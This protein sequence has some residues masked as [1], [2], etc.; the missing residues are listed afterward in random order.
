MRTAELLTPSHNYAVVKLPERSH[1]GVVFQG[2]SL[3]VLLTDISN[4]SV[5]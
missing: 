2:D 5:F 4:C 3:H 1:P